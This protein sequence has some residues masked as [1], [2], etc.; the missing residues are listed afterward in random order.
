MDEEAELVVG[1]QRGDAAAFTAL[2][3]R[4]YSLALGYACSLLRDRQHAEDAVQEAFTEAY[5][6]L[7]RLDDPD[8]FAAWLRTIVR[9]RC[10]RWL[11]RRDLILVPDLEE[12]H[13]ARLGADEALQQ[14]GERPDLLRR[15]LQTLPK[16]ERDVVALFYLADCSQRE[17]AA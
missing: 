10:L 5:T 1:A 14:S 17:I 3:H 12:L 6:S 2:V 11:R 15:A 4:H 8:A 13:A 7:S 9:H 16:A